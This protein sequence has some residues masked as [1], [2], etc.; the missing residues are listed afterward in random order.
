MVM[1][2]IGL[3][4]VWNTFRTP[5]ETISTHENQQLTIESVLLQKIISLPELLKKSHMLKQNGQSSNS[6]TDLSAL[7]LYQLFIQAN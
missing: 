5:N 1:I 4:C 2:V 3:E 7:A 6:E